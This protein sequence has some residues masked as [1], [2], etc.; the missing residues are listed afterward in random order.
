MSLLLPSLLFTKNGIEFW[1][2]LRI[3]DKT[4][5]VKNIDADAEESWKNEIVHSENEPPPFMVAT[6][7]GYFQRIYQN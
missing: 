2:I 1:I 7:S 6:S 4:S 3:N 5:I